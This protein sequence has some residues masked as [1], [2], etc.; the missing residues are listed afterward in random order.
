MT[1]ITCKICGRLFN[2]LRGELCTRCLDRIEAVYPRIREYIR[3]RPMQESLSIEGIAT[4]MQLD[5][6]YIKS[7]VE[8]GYLDQYADR[9]KSEKE[10][11]EQKKKVFFR[12]IREPM[13]VQSAP[14][15]AQQGKRSKMYGQ[16]RYKSSRR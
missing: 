11:D 5:P 15:H 16:D 8:M 10:E 13:S 2:S 9:F 14:Q 12:C 1:L 3:E 6:L 7:L 4:V